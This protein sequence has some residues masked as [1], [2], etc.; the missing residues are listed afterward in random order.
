[1][2]GLIEYFT[3]A[4]SSKKSGKYTE[5]NPSDP[6]TWDVGD[7]LAGTAGYSM[8]L[9]RFYKVVKKTAKQF[10]V[11]RLKGE[12]ISGSRNGQWREIATDEPYGDEEYKARITKY[13]SLKIDGTS[14]HLW[15]GQPLYGDDM[16]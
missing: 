1:M 6:E 9:P 11:V 13:G 14:V 7:I 5:K 3:E 15:D 8:C 2:I 16:D 4:V 10:T 12:I